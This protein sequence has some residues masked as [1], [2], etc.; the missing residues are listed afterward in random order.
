MTPAPRGPVALL[1]AAA[2]LF[3]AA[4]GS[5]DDGGDEKTTKPSATTGSADTGTPDRSPTSSSPR[6]TATAPDDPDRAEDE[7]RKAWRGFFDP[8]VPVEKKTALVEDGVQYELMIQGFAEDKRARELRVRVDSVDF[9]SSRDADVG[10]TLLRGDETIRPE[11]PGESVRQDDDWKI[12]F[13]T[14]CSLADRGEDVPKP[15][16]C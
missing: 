7:I 13:R 1:A 8:D 6:P 11:K 5:G 2:L 10:Y 16:A 14:L 15:V 3:T 12:S 9:T 4:C